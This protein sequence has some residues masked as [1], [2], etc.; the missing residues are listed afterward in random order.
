[1]SPSLRY[2][3][4]HAAGE[5]GWHIIKATVPARSLRFAGDDL[6][7]WGYWGSPQD[8]KTKA[9]VASRWKPST[10]GEVERWAE[11]FAYE[12]NYTLGTCDLNRG[13][14]DMMSNVFADWFEDQTGV[15]LEIWSGQGFLPPLGK[16]ANGLWLMLSGD[17]AHER[18]VEKPLGHVVVKMGDWVV[19]LTGGQ[20]GGLY[21]DPVYPFSVFKRN[22]S[23]VSRVR[24]ADRKLNAIRKMMLQ[25]N[26]E[27]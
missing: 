13:D 9:R 5:D 12:N 11:D 15:A 17:S 22:W 25:M 16:D 24:R 3:K 2:A 4:D 23:E 14:C 8:G 27:W 7:E 20:F 10:I 1:M 18:G 6:M 19:D 21:S 26:P